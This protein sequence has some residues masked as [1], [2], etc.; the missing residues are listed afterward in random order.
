MFLYLEI[1]E[2]KHTYER[3]SDILSVQHLESYDDDNKTV[4]AKSHGQKWYLMSL[5]R[6]SSQP[7]LKIRTF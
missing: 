1:Q 5:G 2:N 6:G 7:L 4:N 3:Q